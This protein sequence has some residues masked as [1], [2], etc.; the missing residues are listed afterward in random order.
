MPKM[1]PLLLLLLLLQGCASCYYLEGKDG[2]IEMCDE[3]TNLMDCSG[4]KCTRQKIER[5]NE[6]QGS[7][8][9]WRR[10]L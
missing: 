2:L 4:E 1:K 10:K 5:T 7:L 6:M 3:E 9:M 8:D